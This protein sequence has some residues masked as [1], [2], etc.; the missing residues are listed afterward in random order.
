MASVESI[1]HT[2]CMDIGNGV[3]VFYHCAVFDHSYNLDAYVFSWNNLLGTETIQAVKTILALSPEL[4][5][6]GQV[7]HTLLPARASASASKSR[8]ALVS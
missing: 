2:K 8:T 6:L 5:Q 1:F 7:Y 3:D 4:E